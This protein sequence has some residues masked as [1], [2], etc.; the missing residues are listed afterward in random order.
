MNGDGSVCRT[1]RLD[2][3]NELFCLLEGRCAAIGNW[4]TKK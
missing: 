2:E 1:L 3:P 4:Q